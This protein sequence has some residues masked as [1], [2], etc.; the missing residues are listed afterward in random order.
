VVG[1]MI[2]ALAFGTGLPGP[3]T[4][5]GGVLML[6]G[7]LLVVRADAAATDASETSMD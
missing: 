5:V 6:A 4:V 7:L 1:S 3:A 2:G